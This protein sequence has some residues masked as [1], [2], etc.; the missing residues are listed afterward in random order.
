MTDTAQQTLDKIHEILSGID[1]P[2]GDA[3]VLVGLA[4]E[5]LNSAAM[6]LADVIRVDGTQEI[7]EAIET[8]QAEGAAPDEAV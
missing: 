7:A 5:R 2:G 3:G 4:R 6:I 1:E 8:A